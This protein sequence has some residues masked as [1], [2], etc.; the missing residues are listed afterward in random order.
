MCVCVSVLTC[1]K[2]INSPFYLPKAQAQYL[3]V[4]MVIRRDCGLSKLC[5]SCEIVCQ[6]RVLKLS[7][8][9]G[10]LSLLQRWDSLVIY[11][12]NNK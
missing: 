4:P 1:I 9:P 5:L 6:Q 7:P 2:Y 10:Y 12:P 8:G 3:P 11:T